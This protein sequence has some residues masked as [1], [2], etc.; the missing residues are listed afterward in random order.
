L[1]NLRRL[2]ID[3]GKAGAREK[4]ERLIARL[5]KLQHPSAQ[6][7]RPKQ[8]DWGIDVFVGKLTSGNISVWQAKYFA[9]RIGD[10]QKG[11]IRQ[12]FNQIID[13]SKEIGFKVKA[14]TLCIPGTFAGDEKIWW[15][16]WYR[17]KQKETGLIIRLK[18]NLD[19]VTMLQTRDALPLCV[20]F[21]LTDKGEL[22]IPERAIEPLPLTESQKYNRSLFILKL[23][24]ADVT[25]IESA[26]KQFFNAEIV[27]R[28]IHDK[29]DDLEIAELNDLYEKIHSLWETR[30]IEAMQSQNIEGETRRVYT[31]MLR[32]IEEK[33]NELLYCHRLP[34]SFFHKKGLMQ[35]MADICTVGWT[36]DYKRLSKKVLT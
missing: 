4:F 34:I 30:F 31:M 27:S 12:S 33:N 2:E 32:L 15:E 11:E 16:K 29:N 35:Q 28:E 17:D 25:E 3:S 24:A 5:V 18:E 26:K 22:L 13:K 21:N 6:E 10:A 7:I 19:I 1:I 36:P 9:D 20:E 23:L 14:W 8:G